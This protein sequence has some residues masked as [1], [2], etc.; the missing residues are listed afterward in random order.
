MSEPDYSRVF[1]TRQAGA[2]IDRIIETEVTLEEVLAGLPD[3]GRLVSL[4]LVL[5]RD[6]PLSR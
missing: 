5:M 1:V 4:V 6:H 2:G 3:D